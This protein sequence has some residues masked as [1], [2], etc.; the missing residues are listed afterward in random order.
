MKNTLLLF[1][2]LAFVGVGCLQK[3]VTPDV[4]EPMGTVDEVAAD[5]NIIVDY[6]VEGGVVTSPLTIQGSARVFENTVEWRI[7]NVDGDE[8]DRGFTTT[9]APDVGEFGTFE[10]RV[11]L[12][13]IEEETFYLEVFAT[14]PRDGAEE[15]KVVMELVPER[16]GK[17]SVNVFFVDPALIDAGGDCSQVDFEKRTVHE[18]VNVRRACLA[19][20]A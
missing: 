14:S 12:P 18:T 8:L 19:R 10:A 20:V 4:P 9:D 2:C 1:T 16:D 11:F 15:D 13:L 5:V 6:P 7:T 3:P 17:V